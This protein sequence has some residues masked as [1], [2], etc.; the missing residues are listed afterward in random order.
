MNEKKPTHWDTRILVMLA[1]VGVVSLVFTNNVMAT[2][3][4]MISAYVSNASYSMVSRSAVR[5]SKLYHGFTTLFSNFIFYLVLKQLV[6]EN[7]TLSLFIP[8]TVATVYGSYTGAKTSQRIEAFFGITAD[9]TN[10]QPTPQSMLAQKILLVFL[11]VLGLV[12]GIVSQDI[13]A[14]LVVAGLAF[15]DNITFSILRRSRNT[16]NTTYHIFASLLKSLAWYILFQSLTIKGMPFMLFI[17]YCFGSVLGG[18]SGQSISGWIEKKIGATADGHLKS[19]L[20]WYKFIPW[21]SVFVLLLVT[22]FAVLYLGNVEIL[23]ALAGLSALQQISFSVVSRS[24]QRN[25]MTYHIIASIF[26]NGV[27]FL[28]FRQLQIKQWTDEL[29]VPYALGGTIG[30]VTGVGLS[31]GIEKAIGASSESK[32]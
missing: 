6:T 2:I 20:A 30:S 7:M 11:C 15:G 13:I 29:F 21:K 18:L 22:I 23:F 31:M 17:P 27:W 25:N 14:S 24:R 8:Y 26:S 32:K 10:K 1:V 4:L 28:T 12:T 3:V 16:S 5:D 9:T 19:N